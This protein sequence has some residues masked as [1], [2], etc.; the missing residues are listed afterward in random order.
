MAGGLHDFLSSSEPS[1][2]IDDRRLDPDEFDPALWLP[3][4][5][6]PEQAL[7]K[8]MAPRPESHV[9]RARARSCWR[10]R[11]NASRNSKPCAISIGGCN[12]PSDGNR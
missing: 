10:S 2:N 11:D 1:Q 8:L 9:P 4:V 12:S 5:A 7:Q 3:G 6:T